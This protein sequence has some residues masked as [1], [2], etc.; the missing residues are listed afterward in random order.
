M[1][2]GLLPGGV[3]C[4]AVGVGDG[5]AGAGADLGETAATKGVA[6]GCR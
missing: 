4:A 5:A 1:P 2:A 3:G 6:A